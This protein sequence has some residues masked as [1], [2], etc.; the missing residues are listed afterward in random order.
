MK[1]SRLGITVAIAGLTALALV[2]TEAAA[3]T[4]G[5]F[6][7]FAVT[8]CRLSTRVI[9]TARWADPN[10]RWSSRPNFPIA[11]LCGV[12]TTAKAAALNVTVAATTGGGHTSESGRSEPQCRL[13]RRSTFDQRR[14]CHRQRRDRSFGGLQSVDSRRPDDEQEY[15]CFLRDRGAVHRA[16]YNRRQRL[17]PVSREARRERP[18]GWS[19]ETQ[20]SRAIE[21]GRSTPS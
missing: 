11:G 17:F 12:P 16:R 5:P 7:F 10:F 1:I 19:V 6:Q 18:S 13:C 14:A 4:G 3:Q 21:G 8:P 20:G 15:H 2:P 9:Q